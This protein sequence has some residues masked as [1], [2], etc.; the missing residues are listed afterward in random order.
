MHSSIHNT[1]PR[2]V[3]A[4]ACVRHARLS[5]PLQIRPKAALQTAAV[6]SA[7]FS[8]RPTR[9]AFPAAP[10]PPKGGTTNRRSS[11]CRL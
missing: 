6:R 11:W 8:L 5:Q 3:Q 1:D 4:S 10:N 9:T 7:G 2:V